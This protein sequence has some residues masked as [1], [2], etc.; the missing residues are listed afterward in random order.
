MGY[1]L[2][3]SVKSSDNVIVIFILR[4]H[5]HFDVLRQLKKEAFNEYLKTVQ[6]IFTNLMSFLG[7]IHNIF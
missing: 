4:N 3:K 6:V 1:S 5:Y 2:Y 7:N